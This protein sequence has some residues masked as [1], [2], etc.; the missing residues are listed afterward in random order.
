[1]N[2]LIIYSLRQG[3]GRLGK[4]G[5]GGGKWGK[6]GESG[7]KRGKV[8]QKCSS[9]SPLVQIVNLVMFYVLSLFWKL[10]RLKG[11]YTFYI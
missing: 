1:M 8:N 11:Y 2:T 7:G 4:A 6:A 5:E 3:R 10:I 9:G